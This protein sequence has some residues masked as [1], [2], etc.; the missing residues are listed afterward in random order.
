MLPQVRRALE[1]LPT[2]AAAE[3]S[4][5]FWLALM[6]QELGRL[7]KVHLAQIALEEVLA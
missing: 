1:T 2:R 7:L 5:P 4:F 6:V 3:G